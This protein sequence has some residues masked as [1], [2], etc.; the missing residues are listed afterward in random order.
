MIQFTIHSLTHFF[1]NF[2]PSS[3][4]EHAIAV[5]VSKEPGWGKTV[6]HRR[7]DLNCLSVFAL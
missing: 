2:S 5:N 1:I 3:L 4:F 7:H 6:V